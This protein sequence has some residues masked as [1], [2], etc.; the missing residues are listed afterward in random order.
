M[1]AVIG[2]K[3]KIVAWAGISSKAMIVSFS[4]LGNAGIFLPHLLSILVGYIREKHM[5]Y[6]VLRS[7]GIAS[8]RAANLASNK[9]TRAI[10][11]KSSNGKRQ[12]N[13]MIMLV[14]VLKPRRQECN[15]LSSSAIIVPVLSLLTVLIFSSPL[16]FSLVLL[17]CIFVLILM[18]N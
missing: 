3:V 2:Y 10:Q 15:S 9:K 4:S 8:S 6:Y 16:S 7:L 17:I 12:G 5:N 14:L 18:K 13:T 1:L 11:E